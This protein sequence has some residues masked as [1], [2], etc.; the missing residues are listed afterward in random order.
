MRAREE[1]EG[2][3]RA[4][5]QEGHRQRQG[6]RPRKGAW[7]TL[8]YIHSGRLEEGWSIPRAHKPQGMG[9]D[10]DR[11]PAQDT[12]MSGDGARTTKEKAK[13]TPEWLRIEEWIWGK[14]AEK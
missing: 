9:R 13:W 1:N 7:F 10:E 4:S 12:E 14:R 5:N 2:E 3:G 6:K 8:R 11:R